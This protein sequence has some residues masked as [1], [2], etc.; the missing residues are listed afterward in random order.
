MLRIDRA[1]QSS[2]RYAGASGA[3]LVEAEGRC[4]LWSVHAAFDQPGEIQQQL[5]EM[6][7]GERWFTLSRTVQGQ[8]FG[9]G[10]KAMFAVALGVNA[11]LAT[12]IGY[13]R[14]LDLESGAATPVGLGC[15]A[16]TRAGCAQRSAPP[17]GRTLSFNERERGLT[18]F[19]FTAD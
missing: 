15:A 11:E 6:E 10:G 4:P 12:P 3:L 2:K 8:G 13:A 7:G 17:K 14:G 5:V 1:G 19:E 18:P 16:C 9:A